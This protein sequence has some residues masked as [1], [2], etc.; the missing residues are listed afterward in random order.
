MMFPLIQTNHILLQGIHGAL[1]QRMIAPMRRYGTEIVAG[2]SVGQGGTQVEDIPVFD[3]V[4]QAIAAVGDID[5]SVVCVPPDQVA[6]AALEA[7]AA[8]IRQLVLVPPQVP[9]LDTLSLINRAKAT[10]TVILGAG[11]AGLI[12]PDRFLVGTLD[13]R[14]YSVGSVGIIDRTDRVGDAIAWELSQAGIGQS[15]AVHLGTGSILG[16][17]FADWIPLFAHNDD[18]KAIVL[19]EQHLWGNEAAATVIPPHIDKPIFA[20]VAGQNLPV[21]APPGDSATSIAAQKVHALPH[22]NTAAEKIA[23]Y[24]AAKIRV[25]QSPQQLTEWLAKALK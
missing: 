13:P 18:T 24:K 9:P 4:E 7:I 19:L 14:C 17:T 6:D 16:T 3:L 2:V 21:K 1:A 10:G 25:A 20:Y 5:T 23:A 8:G 22:T 11:S 15:V 12:V